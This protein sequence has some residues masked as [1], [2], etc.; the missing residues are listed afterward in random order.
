MRRRRNQLPLAEIE[1]FVRFR[2]RHRKRGRQ[3]RSLFGL[4]PAG[5]DHG[6]VA[7]AAIFFTRLVAPPVPAGIRRP[8]MTFS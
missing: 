2:L 7:V 3:C 6:L 8:T 1:D 4:G 5:L